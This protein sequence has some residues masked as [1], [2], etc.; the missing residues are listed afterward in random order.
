MVQAHTVLQIEKR[1]GFQVVANLI[2]VTESVFKYELAIIV[3][4]LLD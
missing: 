1:A 4:K 3:N 2:T